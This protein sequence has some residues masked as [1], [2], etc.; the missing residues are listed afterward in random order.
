ML[1]SASIGGYT[2]NRH[3][4]QTMVS[5]ASCAG[6]MTKLMKAGVQLLGSQYDSSVKLQ[7]QEC[8]SKSWSDEST[9]Q[10]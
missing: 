6:T 1:D 9:S 10:I 7:R 8:S 3:G 4:R 5:K 2:N